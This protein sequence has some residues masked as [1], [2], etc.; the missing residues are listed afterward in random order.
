MKS[1]FLSRR[2]R[3]PQQNH[4]P[5]KEQPFFSKS[6]DQEK[7]PFFQAGAQS[8]NGQAIQA[9]LSI[10]QPGDKYEQEA[11][12]VANQV[13]SGQNQTPVLQ[14]QE[15]STVQR[16]TLATPQEDEKLSTAE[17]RMEKDKLIQEKPELQREQMP[18][19]EKPVQKM[20]AP[21]EEEALPVQQK[22]DPKE[23]EPLQKMDAPEE[24][25]EPVQMAKE[26]EEPLL[27]QKAETGGTTTASAHLS[28]RIQDSSGKGAQLAGHTRAE[29]EQAFGTDFSNVNIHTDTDAVQMN[30][31][32]GAQAFTH[33]QDVYFNAGKYNPENS[34]GKRL[35]AHELTHVVQQD[36]ETIKRKGGNST[37]QKTKKKGFAYLIVY[38]EYKIDSEIEAIGKVKGPGHAGVLLVSPEG[39][40]KYYEYGRY[41]TLD[42]TKGKVQK[43]TIPDAKMDNEGNPDSASVKKVMTSLSTKAGQGGK[44]E[45]TFFPDLDFNKMNTF[46]TQKFQETN[47]GFKNYKKDRKAYS[48]YDNNCGTFA[49][50]VIKQGG[51]LKT[52]MF[53]MVNTPTNIASEYQEEG[54]EKQNFSGTKK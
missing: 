48:L 47:K 52:P 28:S 15:I 31:E 51:E 41:A 2:H 26:E 18:E 29:M 46:A 8:G 38:P 45:A 11:D 6:N 43:R 3:N 21:K 22:A 30:K 49:M 24:E 4:E 10:G 33:G 14:R 17:S 16:A 40:T 44:I 27:Q 35:L 42:G 20:D 32:L 53:I 13:V 12:S 37:I 54:Y 9:K 39:L 36:N 34:S 25:K 1:A 7:Q 23:E 19:E 50:D 5:E